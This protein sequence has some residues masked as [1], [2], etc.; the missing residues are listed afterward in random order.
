L[1][2][3][4]PDRTTEDQAIAVSSDGN[5]KAILR[6]DHN[7]P[8]GSYVIKAVY[9]SQSFASVSFTL[10]G[11]EEKPTTPKLQPSIP[12]DVDTTPPFI[13]IP[14]DI[15]VGATQKSGAYVKFTVTAFDNVD[16]LITPFCSKSSGS[17]FAIGTTTVTCRATDSSG[18]NIQKSFTVTVNPLV[19]VITQ[20]P[21]LKIP[22]YVKNIATFW[23]EDQIDDASFVGAIEYMIEQRIIT[24][25]DVEKSQ[26]ITTQKAVPDWVKTTT[27]YWTSGATSDKEYADTIQWL[28]GVG[29]IAVS[30]TTIVTEEA[31]VVQLASQLSDVDSDGIL[32]DEDNCP[33]VWN[34]DQLDSDNNGMGDPC[35]IVTTHEILMYI[36]NI[37]DGNYAY[38]LKTHVIT[39]R[40]GESHNQYLSSAQVEDFV[41][42]IDVAKE[43]YGSHYREICLPDIDCFTYVLSGK[44]SIP[45]STIVINE[46]DEVLLRVKNRIVGECVGVNVVRSYDT[47]ESDGTLVVMNT[48]PN[49]CAPEEFT[50]ELYTYHWKA[51]LGSAGAYIYYDPNLFERGLFGAIIVNG[52][53]IKALIDGQIT[54]IQTS[55]IQKEFVIFMEDSSTMW[56]TEVNNWLGGLQKPLWKNPILAAK[57][58]DMVRFHV[59]GMGGT[60]V[61]NFHIHAHKWLEPGTTDVIDTRTIRPLETHTFVIKAGEGVGTGAW[62]YHC[63]VF[64]HMQNGMIGT[65]QVIS[66]DSVSIAV[67]VLP[68]AQTDIIDC[69]IGDEMCIQTG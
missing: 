67:N 18:N 31:I 25:P 32:N 64:S 51:E 2:I 62:Q 56:V 8:K 57:E 5:F 52:E 24:I 9:G 4:K 1:T 54:E 44:V 33:S 66:H 46:G 50:G 42:I 41:S 37:E 34:P 17:L 6:L 20:A 26:T 65:F 19:T 59:L 39:T 22:A 27:E 38:L 3:I 61:H 10:F 36:V 47:S 53:N 45:G 35:N 29:I 48:G 30:E 28:V 14:S 16:D 58:N 12:F 15:V 11:I 40:M 23:Q 63:H 43:R 55:E 69:K 7:Y 60:T 21:T 49:Q 68:H 13:V